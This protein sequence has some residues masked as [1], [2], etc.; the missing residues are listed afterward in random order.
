MDLGVVYHGIL[1]RVVDRVL[2]DRQDLCELEPKLT[3]EMIRNFAGEIG[4]TIRGELMLS[5]ARN[6]YLLKRIEKTLSRV[7]ATQKAVLSRGA[8][9]P[10][11]AELNFGIGDGGLPP[12]TIRTPRGNEV[13]L[14]GKIDRVDRS[15]NGDEVAVI[16]YKMRESRLRLD[17]VIHGLSLQLLTYLLVL[18]ANGQELF[19]AKV[20]PVAAFYA[21]LL[22]SLESI[23]HPEDATPPDHPL[24]DLK[25]KPRGIFDERVIDQ[26]DDQMTAG[27]SSQVV[28][29][30]VNQ[31]GSLGNA[32][33]NDAAEADAFAA[34]L[35]FVERRIGELADD[36]IAGRIDA[37]PYRIGQETPCAHCDF[38]SVCRFDPGINEYHHL[39]AMKRGDALQFIMSK[40]G[41]N[42]GK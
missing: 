30:R 25:T 8:F 10:A 34:V 36:L 6:Q 27:T 11:F 24:F 31:D 29:C 20:K 35:R 38:R 28:Q 42:R 9:R 41:A 4:K 14:R 22:R 1:E 2:K 26:L 16:D 33:Y 18:Q 13:L 23:K 12:L 7:C 37:W 40:S 32:N 5:T 3:E 39:P 17:Q 21:K 19:Q 15:Q